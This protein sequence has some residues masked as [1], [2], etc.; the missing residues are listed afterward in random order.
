MQLT[1]LIAM[2]EN[3]RYVRW[4]LVTLLLVFYLVVSFQRSVDCAQ[5]TVRVQAEARLTPESAPCAVDVT[6]EGTLD[7]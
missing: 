5:L 2:N 3:T 7:D 6:F 1:R 4:L